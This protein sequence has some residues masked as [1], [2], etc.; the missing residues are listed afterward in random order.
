MSNDTNVRPFDSFV[1]RFQNIHCASH[2]SSFS[3]AAD[4]TVPVV[5]LLC[6]CL[7]APA[8]MGCRRADIMSEQSRRVHY[9]HDNCPREPHLYAVTVHTGLCSAY[10]LSAK[11]KAVFIQVSIR[12]YESRRSMFQSPVWQVYVALYG[13]DGTSQT[14][15]LSVPGC[16][17]FRRNSRDTFVLR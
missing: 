14:R 9:L 17:L 3:E 11:V 5:L 6:V 12:F 16:T 7:Y 2:L 1:W 8:L 13:G 4:V 10:R 15:E